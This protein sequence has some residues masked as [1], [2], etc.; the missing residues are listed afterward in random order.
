MIA[1]LLI[2][3]RVANNSALTSTTVAPRGVYSSEV[4]NQG[5]LTGG[6][7]ALSNGYLMDPVGERGI[8]CG[9]LGVEIE[10]SMIDSYRDRV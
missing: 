10:A 1:P 2:I 4:E 5:K 7:D 3:Q 8:N 9:K 6:S